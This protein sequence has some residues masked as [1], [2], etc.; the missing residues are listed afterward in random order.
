MN[1]RFD[2]LTK[3]L[4]Q[5]VTRRQALTRF[6]IGLAGMALAAFA[7]SA[8]ATPGCKSA[9]QK[10]TADCDNCCSGFCGCGGPPGGTPRVICTCS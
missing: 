6:G 2:T 9:G 3:G 1:N 7:P 8:K 10:C 4:A 5:S